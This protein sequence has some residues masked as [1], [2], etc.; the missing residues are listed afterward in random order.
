MIQADAVDCEADLGRGESLRLFRVEV[1]FLADG[2]MAIEFHQH[3][4]FGVDD[5]EFD[6]RMGAGEFAHEKF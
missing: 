6:P 1:L 3:L 2:H 4:P 5:A